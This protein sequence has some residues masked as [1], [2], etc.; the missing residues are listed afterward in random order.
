MCLI[1]NDITPERCY[2]YNRRSTTYGKNISYLPRP[3]VFEPF[4]YP[5]LKDDLR[6]I[7]SVSRTRSLFAYGYE[8]IAIRIK[9]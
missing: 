1:Y 6:I 4:M 9:N 7:S 5:F 8:N 2:F 3:E